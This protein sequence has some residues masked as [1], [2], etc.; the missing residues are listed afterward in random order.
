M[1]PSA[2][3]L[4]RLLLPMATSLPLTTAMLLLAAGTTLLPQE[5]PLLLETGARLPLREAVLPLVP[6][7]RVLVVP[8][9]GL[10]ANRASPTVMA[11]PVCAEAPPTP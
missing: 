1:V 5:L 4:T 10:L 9:P 6:A 11:T 2:T 3:T 8:M 7:L